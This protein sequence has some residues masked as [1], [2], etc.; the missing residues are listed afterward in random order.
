MIKLLNLL[1]F[2]LVGSYRLEPRWDFMDAAQGWRTSPFRRFS[3]KI[4]LSQKGRILRGMHFK[5]TE[6]G[7]TAHLCV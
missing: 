1:F 5:V 3:R 4:T 2:P 6:S 7:A